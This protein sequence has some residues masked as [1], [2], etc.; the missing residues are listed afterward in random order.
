MHK[1]FYLYKWKICSKC[2]FIHVYIKDTCIKFQRKIQQS[3]I[4][5]QRPFLNSSNI[6]SKYNKMPH[7]MVE[8]GVPTFDHYLHSITTHKYVPLEHHTLPYSSDSLPSESSAHPSCTSL[9]LSLHTL[10]PGGDLQWS[11]RSG[12]YMSA[13]KHTTQFSKTPS[14][15]LHIDFLS[16]SFTSFPI[17]LNSK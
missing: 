12:T 3:C 7:I 8:F 15:V 6:L 5:I 4:P 13:T 11:P 17:R 16:N 1:H 9:S 2:N 14:P 10:Q